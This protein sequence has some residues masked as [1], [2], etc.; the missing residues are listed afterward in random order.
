MIIV[1]DYDT[2]EITDIM[3]CDNEIEMLNDSVATATEPEELKDLTVKG[4]M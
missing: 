4:F 1:E 2:K 3:Q